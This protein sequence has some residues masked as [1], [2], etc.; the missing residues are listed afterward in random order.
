MQQMCVYTA[1]MHMDSVWRAEGGNRQV[2]CRELN[3]LTSHVP[4]IPICVLRSPGSGWDLQDRAPEAGGYGETGWPRG[5][6][7]GVISLD[8]GVGDTPS[9]RACR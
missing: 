9:E 7:V 6:E 4:V 5:G 8:V 1:P 3:H 2:G